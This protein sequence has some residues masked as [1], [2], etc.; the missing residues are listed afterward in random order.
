MAAAL[1]RAPTFSGP[2][3]SILRQRIGW[4]TSLTALETVQ[5][6]KRVLLRV[7]SL[8]WSTTSRIVMRSSGGK[9]VSMAGGGAGELC[10]M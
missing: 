9:R 3:D 8:S 1:K 4:A 2:K 5:Q 7:Y 10:G 6:A